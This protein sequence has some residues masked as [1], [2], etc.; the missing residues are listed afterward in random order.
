[1]R[2]RERALNLVSDNPNNPSTHPRFLQARL[3]LGR[4]VLQKRETAARKAYLAGRALEY[5]INRH[6]KTLRRALYTARSPFEMQDYM[7][8]LQTVFDDYRHR[9]RYEVP[10]LPFLPV[11]GLKGSF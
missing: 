4:K 7:T 6:T 8:C 9:Q 2:R 5:E 3:E 11:I 1:M 10:G